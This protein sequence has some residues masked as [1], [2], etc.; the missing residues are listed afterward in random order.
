MFRTTRFFFVL[1]S[2]LCVT[3]LLQA[4]TKS[5]ATVTGTDKVITVTLPAPF[6]ET[7]YAGTFSA[8]IDGHATNL[9]CIDIKHQLQYNAPYTDVE[10]TD[11]LMTYIL[12]N[13]YPYK[14]YPYTNALSTVE[15]E[16]GAV[17]MALWNLSDNLDINGCTNVD[18]TVKA[19]ALAIVNDAK[20]YGHNL[21]LNSFFI[22]IP[23]QSFSTGSPISFTIKAFDNMGVAM[24]NVNI[25]ISTTAGTL[26]TTT[27]KTGALGV[28]PTIT[29]T[30]NGNATTATITVS[31]TVGIPAGTK[32]FH[33]ADPN[34][35][36]KLI[37][38]TPT[39]A[40]R[41]ITKTITWFDE[42][43]LALTK[44]ADVNKVNDGD[45]VNYT[46]VVKNIGTQAAQNVTVSD[47]LPAILNYVSC[48]PVGAY[49]PISGIWAV[50]SLNVGD[51]AVLV[52]KTKANF[53]N[54]NPTPFTLGPVKDYNLF[55]IDTL[56]QPSA[57]TQG[58][59]AV[60]GYC[61][62]RGYSVGDQLPA[63]SGNVLVCGNHLTFITGRVY[64]GKAVYQNYITSTMGFSADDGIV[65]DSV[66]NFP[67]AKL[68]VQN[69]SSQLATLAKTDTIASAYGTITLNAHKSG[70]NVFYL[71][72]S[73][74]L[75]SNALVINAPAN[76]TVL[77]NISGDSTRIFGGFDV[78]GTTK[79]KVLLNF[80]EATKLTFS[81]ADVRASVL[82]PKATL[83]FPAGIVSG[84]LIVRCMYGSGQVN[85]SP[86]TGVLSRDTSITNFATCEGASVSNMPNYFNFGLTA[87]ARISENDSPN[88]VKG[89]SNSKASEFKL[90]QNYPNPFNPSTIVRFNMANAGYA[91]VAIYNIT[92][93]LIKV[94]ADGNFTQGS[95][96]VVFN[97]N[98]LPSGIYLCRMTSGT[99][100]S[101]QKMILQ[102]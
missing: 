96:E 9:Y 75:T 24:P 86:F 22:D 57:D 6:S 60:G 34:G 13:Y 33:Q 81:G 73:K 56:I 41:T 59:L 43:K 79:D 12:N 74:L 101:V 58:K 19:R 48:L 64:N 89:G 29:L 51:S 87:L 46:I 2:V 5:I 20:T 55:V 92:G 21:S 38:A 17:Q 76:S 36:Q 77:V 61:D 72:G 10:Q 68:Y 27:T 31:G 84:Q 95:H 82:A 1:V 23:T 26:S 100:S 35:K 83:N 63:N 93:Q 8:S 40:A 14:T 49:S 50:G 37:L 44:K 97:A 32:Y 80:Y 42:I 39:I 85:L 94:L 4:K 28:S 30:P 7:V 67:A 78:N 70:L 98:N 52:I 45:F 91:K 47:Q 54:T 15:K 88:S 69:L 3:S 11:S 66:L 71:D 102:K 53:S 16:A 62:L 25:T 65:K 90:E 18:A 99:F